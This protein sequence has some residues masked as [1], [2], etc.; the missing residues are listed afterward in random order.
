[1]ET[2]FQIVEGKNHKKA[3]PIVEGY[4]EKDV[5]DEKIV[6]HLHGYG[7][8]TE[9]LLVMTYCKG[10]NDG[11]DELRNEFEAQPPTK[12]QIVI[13]GGLVTC[14]NDIPQGVDYE[15]VDWDRL[16]HSGACPRCDE[17]LD[18]NTITCPHCDFAVND[19]IYRCVNCDWSGNDDIWNGGDRKCPTCSSVQIGK[20]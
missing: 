7:S 9:P 12:I 4:G 13:R 19:G 3:Q 11:M 10:F 16:E 17:A 1:M 20:R 5:T 15:V 6:N 8:P 14:V 2:A 18:E